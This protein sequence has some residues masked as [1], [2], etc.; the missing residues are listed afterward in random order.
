MKKITAATV[1]L[2]LLLTGAS[3]APALKSGADKD[4]AE[5]P[6]IMYHHMSPKARLRG[7]YVIDPAAFENDLKWLSA[8][9]YTAVTVS[10]VL[11]FV[12][13]EKALPDKPVIISFDD[14]QESFY[15]YALPLLEKYG[16][17]AELAVIGSCAEQFSENPDHNPD[18]A[19]MDWDEIRLASESGR[20]EIVNHTWSLHKLKPRKGCGILPGESEEEYADMLSKDIEKLGEALE[21]AGVGRP[22]IFAYPFGFISP[23]AE[24]VLVAEGFKAALTCEGKINHLKR[25]EVKELLCLGRFNRPGTA[26]T[27]RFFSKTLGE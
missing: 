9:G 11:S 6:I 2:L 10:D 8:H 20:A 27:W 26:E 3:A 21:R 1:L 7:T 17:C 25:G 4:T 15:I 23:E 22:E 12:R 13:G 5:L 14:A 18:Y 24:K 19:Y 16:M